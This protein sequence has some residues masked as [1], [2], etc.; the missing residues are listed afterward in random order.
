MPLTDDS[1]TIWKVSFRWAGLNPDSL[2]YHFF[3]PSDAKENMRLLLTS[4]LKNELYCTSLKPKQLLKHATALDQSNLTKLNNIISDWKYDRDFLKI[5]YINRDDFAHWC[6]RNS[7]PFPEFWFPPGWAINELK[8]QDWLLFENPELAD[9]YTNTE[10]LLIENKTTASLQKKNA[11]KNEELW[12]PTII[13]ARTIW[14]QDKSLTTAEVINQIKGMNHLKAAAF[15]ESAIRKHI[16]K[17]SPTQ[18]KPGRKPKKN[19]PK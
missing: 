2:K 14:S 11:S 18:G 13:A 16:A 8:Q 4:V 7:I 12:E 3:I 15:S 9:I 5:H 6:N 19:Y 10:P 17:L 1:L